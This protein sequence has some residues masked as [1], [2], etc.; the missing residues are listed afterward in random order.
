MRS[1][2]ASNASASF[3]SIWSSG[4]TSMTTPEP[5]VIRANKPGAWRRDRPASSRRRSQNGC[6]AIMVT[7][8]S[9]SSGIT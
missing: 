2:V 8:G 1:W 9:K 3:C 4:R 7:C 5:S 6:A